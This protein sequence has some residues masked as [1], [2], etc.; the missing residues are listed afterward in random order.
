MVCPM[1]YDQLIV[2]PRI[3]RLK[4]A[5]MYVGGEANLRTLIKV[6]W[7]KPIIQHHKNTSFDIRDLDLAIDKAKLDGFP[8]IK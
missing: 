4:A 3:L 7:V 6:G 5:Q 2:P 8:V 1:K